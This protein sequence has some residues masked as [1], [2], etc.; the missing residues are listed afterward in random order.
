MV[1]FDRIRLTGLLQR[2]PRKGASPFA[3]AVCRPHSQPREANSASRAAEVAAEAV[4]VAVE[5]VVR[6]GLEVDASVRVEDELA[7]DLEDDTHAGC[8][9]DAQLSGEGARAGQEVGGDLEITDVR[10]RLAGQR[11]AQG[12]G[13]ANTLHGSDR[14]ACLV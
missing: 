13:R 9:V 5:V 8:G 6:A 12:S 3:G 4:E 10:E 7:D 11:V 1:T 2:S 14:C